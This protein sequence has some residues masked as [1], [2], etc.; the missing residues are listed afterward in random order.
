[1]GLGY[2][3]PTLYRVQTHSGEGYRAALSRRAELTSMIKT[4]AAPLI[5]S[6]GRVVLS[7]AVVVVVLLVVAAAAGSSSRACGSCHAMSAYADA[8][9]GSPHEDVNCYACHLSE[10]AWGWP[11]FKTLEIGVMY[12]SALFEG[13]PSGPVLETSRD[14]CLDCHD[15]VLETVTNSNGLRIVHYACAV[16]QT[17]D[18]CHATV[19]H[20][21]VSRWPREPVMEECIACHLSSGAVNECDSCHLGKNETER[22]AVGPWQ[23]THGITW[24]DM[25]GM[26]SISY[27]GTCHPD[28]Y[29]VKCHGLKLPHPADF[30][31]THGGQ[32]LQPEASCDLCHDVQVVC[33]GCH[34]LPMPH[35]ESFLSEHS[36]VAESIDD[37]TCAT[38]H[39]SEGCMRCHELHVH[40]G[41]TDGTLGDPV[42]GAI[43][44]PGDGS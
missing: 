42:T 18:G 9:V 10:G 26:G 4:V 2:P 3:S 22:L 16:G 27:C 8:L 37:E 33:E 24:R 36:S 39:R 35:P 11:A 1:M 17:C 21:D 40:P 12:P 34:G 19:A 25:H 43:R 32:A 20:G 30:G 28:D 31:R 14:A 38:C 6:R 7:L 41:S 5:S 23:V 44:G 29:C 15:S 13:A